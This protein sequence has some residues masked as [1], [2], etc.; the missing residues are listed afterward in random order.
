MHEFFWLD[1]S[2][3][4]LTAI[5]AMSLSLIVLGAAPPHT[6][7]RFFTLFTLCV[8]L[9]TASGFAMRILLFLGVDALK[10]WGEVSIFF[11]LLLGPALL[12][13]TPRYVE[14]STHWADRVSLVCLLLILVHIWP[15]FRGYLIH[16]YYLNANGIA[17]ST[18]TLWGKFVLGIPILC[19]VWSLWLFWQERHR[20][21]EVLLAFSVLILLIGLILGEILSISM[22]AFSFAVVSSVVIAGYVVIS[23]Q[24]FNPLR[25]RTE[26]LQRE[27]SERRRVE[28]ALRNSEAKLRR[29]M[30]TS[31]VGITIVDRDGQIT[32]ANE[33]AQQIFGLTRDSIVQRTYNASEWRITDYEGNPFPNEQLPFQQVLATGKPVFNVR[34]A[35]ESPGDRRMLLSINAAPI[36]DDDNN[37]DAIVAAI[38]DVTQQNQ[39]MRGLQESEQRFRALFENMAEGVA[40]HR[41]VYDDNGR[42]V[43]YVITD[44]NATYESH[45]GLAPSWAVGKCGSEVY[46]ADTPP[47]FDL[48]SAVALTGKPNHVEVYFAPMQRHF[49][50][51]IC[52]PGEAQFVTI[53]EDITQRKQAEAEILRLQHLLQN[54]TNSMPSALITLDSDGRVLTWNPAAAALTGQPSPKV[55][56]Q[57][58]WDVCPSLQ[59]YQELVA[60]VIRDRQTAHLHRDQT[61]V[62]DAVIYH[63]VSIFPLVAETVEGIVLRIDDVTH[64]VQLEEIM[65]QSA[66]LASVGRLAAGMAHEINNPLGSMMQGAQVLQLAL[67]T[68]RKHTQELVQTYALDPTALDRYLNDRGIPEYLEGIR[69]AG[70]RAAKI[71]SDLLSFSRKQSSHAAP[72][73]INDLV[74]Q[75]LALIATDYDLKKHYD[76]QDIEIVKILEPELPAVICDGQ[77]I[78]QVI[79]NLVRN[80]AQAMAE[81][82]EKATNSGYRPQ[83]ILRTQKIEI[84]LENQTQTWVQLD[85]ADNGPGIPEKMRARLFEPFF[86]TKEVGQGTGLG[87]WLC[88][89]I[90]V[91]RHHGRI[92]LEAAPFPDEKEGTCF[93]IELPASTNSE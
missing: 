36:F 39:A 58:L 86:T 10:F 88:W 4:A 64:R 59:R 69:S 73:Q 1:V 42:P 76:F 24:L 70:A 23:R 37:L 62:G 55:G 31:P 15:L 74:E 38:T 27:I 9:W 41:L 87:L 83:L 29:V 30:E 43:D 89:S 52:S 26:V 11:F 61:M 40:W 68:K 56:G 35:I 91:E 8:A 28:H 67:D 72:R 92:H 22:S 65:L 90:V 47:Y 79:L 3:Y 85:I 21:Q 63:D 17:Q 2:V 75:T 81:K 7:G 14:H 78:Q 54:I 93:V 71:I 49:K 44:V 45:T 34:H 18:F 46:G 20:V 25:E 48:F 19:F 13:F 82:K 5:V 77:Q 84:P 16:E 51:S 50:I 57:C 12:L 80:A 60:Q 66:K 53:F 32:F 6:S 33:Q